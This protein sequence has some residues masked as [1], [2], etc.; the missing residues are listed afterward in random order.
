MN[1][2]IEKV[3]FES[4]WLLI[5]FLFILILALGIY[6]YFDIIEFYHYV[7]NIG[8]MNKDTA[9]VT[10]IEL[11]DITMIAFLGKMMITGGYHSFISKEHNYPNENVTSGMLKVKIATSLVGIT[12]I[13]LLKESVHLETLNWQVLHKLVYVH[14]TFLLSAVVLQWVDYLHEKSEQKKHPKE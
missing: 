13:A 2:G 11:I 14:V 12:G 3:V 8:S 7:M 9:M 6:T 5:P 10:F 1:E 4:R